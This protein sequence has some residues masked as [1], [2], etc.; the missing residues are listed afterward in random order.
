MDSL[1][2]T[3][4]DPSETASASGSD[5]G[6]PMSGCRAVMNVSYLREVEDTGR[7]LVR[8]EIEILIPGD[9]AAFHVTYRTA[10]GRRQ[11]A[12]VRGAQVSVIPA[13][14]PHAVSC[15]RQSDMLVI[16]LDRSFF[17]QKAREALG[18]DAPELVERYATVDPF[19]REL[20]NTL[21]HEFRML[22]TLSA[23]YL[24]CL[25]GVIAVHVA[26]HYSGPCTTR[27]AYAGLPP[28]KLNRVEAYIREHFAETIQIQQLA[29]I[30]H[31]SPCHFA[32]MFKK[33]TGQPPHAYITTRRMEYA[34]ELLR[35]SN[36]SLVDVAA[37]A[38]FQTQGHFTG[39]FHRYTGVTPRVY[40]LNCQA[41]R[42]QSGAGRA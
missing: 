4:A 31:M 11:R 18:S 1:T 22:N 38:G 3:A 9:Q 16:T 29:D 15:Q 41:V 25:A 24:N 14:Q 6:R 2:W 8:D 32:R 42:F 40:R 37:K 19:M 26:R 17:H 7:E 36:S 21:R 10:D 12:F 28:H 33:A 30:V 23:G 13:N 39:V 35:E 5:S 27:H 34:K 20:G